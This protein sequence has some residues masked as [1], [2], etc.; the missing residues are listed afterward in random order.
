M[1]LEDLAAAWRARA[2]ELRQWAAA[3][4]AATALERAAEELE[5]SVRSTNA[6]LL[7]LRQASI[8]GG[9]SV[10]HL[11]HLVAEGIIP[12]AGRKGA[13]RIRRAEVPRKAK[14]DPAGSYD[15]G[16]DASQVV[17]R[18]ISLRRA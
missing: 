16:S 11:R 13:P 17:E 9:Y 4:G 10:D 5:E 2:V 14:P 8:E 12:N 18:M 6:E 7:T 3:D 1:K 15:P